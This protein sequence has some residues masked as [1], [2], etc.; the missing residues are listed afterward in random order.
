MVYIFPAFTMAMRPNS[1]NWLSFRPTGPEHT[2]VLGG[3]LVSPETRARHPELAEQRRE[4][5]LRVNGEDSRAT[6]ELARV[7]RS[8]KATRGP[9]SPFEG[10]IAQ[11]YRYLAR[12]LSPERASSLRVV[13]SA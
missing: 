3:Y 5:I 6:T 9:L 7:M 8:S 10:T 12:T 11:F 4:L 2:Q 1:N 13:R